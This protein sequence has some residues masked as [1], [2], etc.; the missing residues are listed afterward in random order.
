MKVTLDTSPVVDQIDQFIKKTKIELAKM[1]LEETENLRATYQQMEEI[2][3][4][5]PT[6]KKAALASLKLLKSSIILRSKEILDSKMGVH[7]VDYFEIFVNGI[8]FIETIY[9]DT[10]ESDIDQSTKKEVVIYTLDSFCR[11]INELIEDQA[12]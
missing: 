10:D 6:K 8:N 1:V 11:D 5:E 7:F 2:D 4:D 12:Q 9:I 3:I